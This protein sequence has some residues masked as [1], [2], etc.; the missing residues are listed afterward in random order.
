MLNLI[1]ND[2]CFNK[3]KELRI[4]ELQQLSNIHIG[5]NCF[6]S[7]KSAVFNCVTWKGVSL[8]ALHRMETL[9]IGSDCFRN[10]NVMT[11]SEMSQLRAIDIADRSLSKCQQV[12]FLDL[13][14]VGECT[15]SDR[16]FS[17]TEKIIIDSTGFF[18]LLFTDISTELE[19]TLQL[20]R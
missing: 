6:G 4:E 10:C 18:F 11:I 15:L 16:V 19:M 3:L 17:K 5:C 13:P 8:I 20:A 9:R 1:F 2:S 7:V 12:T 14:L